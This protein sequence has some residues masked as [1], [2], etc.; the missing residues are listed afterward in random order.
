V[1]ESS[2]SLI[3]SLSE[4]TGELQASFDPT[5]GAAPPDLAT[6]RQRL[7]AHG[8]GEYFLDEQALADFIRSCSDAGQL[9]E[10]V[11]AQRRDGEF[12][13][14]LADD[15]MAAYLTLIPPQGG[16]SEGP[17]VIDA[18]REAGVV[19][20]I[21]QDILDA[22]L[23]A[24]H[25]EH[26]LI[27]KGD[28][29]QEGVATGFES[30]FAEQA[31]AAEAIDE[32]AVIK[33]TDISRLLLVHAHDP[34]MRRHPP[35]PGKNGINIRNEVVLPKPLD[36]EP[37]A[38]GLQGAAPDP[39][40]PD[41]LVATLAGQPV[42]VGNGVKVNPVIDVANVDLET[43][44]ISFEGTL[45]VAGDIRSGMR[46]NVTG[47][48][49]VMGTVEAADITAGGNV[50]V[51]GGIIGRT[52]GRA[53][54]FQALPADTARIRCSGTLQALFAE[55]AHLEAGDSILMG[56]EASHCEL[57][58]RKGIFIGK[59]GAKGGHLVGGTA[60]A[61]EQVECV[62]LGSAAGGKTRVKVGV[63]PYLD[64]VI[65][66]KRQLVQNKIADLDRVLLL[67]QYLKQNPQKDKGGIGEKSENT[68]LQLLGEIEALNNELA[69]LGAQ[70]ETVEQARVKVH[71]AIYF[72]SEIHFGR[73]VL[74]VQDDLG[75]A[76]VRLQDGE[77]VIDH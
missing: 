58:A 68:R 1:D 71:K 2:Q 47:D 31:S 33:L 38:A 40:D 70:L 16:K 21:Q 15:L 54:T 29:P 72:G 64:E 8:C 20:G 7:V 51:G 53:G 57:M 27:A 55:N 34:L 73:K 14:T 5:R 61:T 48:V 3:F 77:I 10:R 41:L 60:Q 30:L 13:L 43:G 11:I 46:V 74:Q 67:Q 6:I 23:A 69:L 42:V 22:A 36:D 44:N 65:L 59:P 45:N 76:T 19:Y 26:L 50:V 18:L 75:A 66:G 63:D 24:G 37:F 56:R 28:P 9:V 62:V 4:D 12:K 17:A 52:E 25:C 35:V 49:M 39:Q 32:H